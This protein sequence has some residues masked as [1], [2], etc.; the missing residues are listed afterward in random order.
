[1]GSK[2]KAECFCITEY[3]SE[4]VVLIRYRVFLKH[5]FPTSRTPKTADEVGIIEFEARA[6]ASKPLLLLKSS[7]EFGQ[8]FVTI[9]HH[10]V[11]E[12]GHHDLSDAVRYGGKGTR[13]RINLIC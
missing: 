13:S 1:M 7:D 9:E 12:M 4:K 11:K 2:R 3:F 6:Y 8:G 5:R 10:G